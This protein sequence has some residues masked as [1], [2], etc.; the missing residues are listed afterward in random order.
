[1]KID[2]ESCGQNA[3]SLKKGIVGNV[4]VEKKKN[5]TL[6]KWL[7]GIYDKSDFYFYLLFIPILKI[8]QG[9]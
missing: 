6:N 7:F 2:C 9:Y 8:H 5:S 3:T 1:V 4:E